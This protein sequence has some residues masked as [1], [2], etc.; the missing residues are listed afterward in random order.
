MPP[1]ETKEFL[2][3]LKIKS[4]II[5][6]VLGAALLQ[7]VATCAAILL[8]QQQASSDVTQELNVL[9]RKNI[10]QIARDV[11]RMAETANGLVQQQVASGLQVARDLMS[12][13]GTPA[14]STDKTVSWQAVN[15]LTKAVVPVTLPELTVGGVW[16]GQNRDPNA[17][18]PLVDDVKRLSGVTS[19]IFQRMNSEG[20][21]LR[22]ATNVEGADHKRA[23]GTYIP[24]VNPDG[25]PN[26]VVAAVLRGETFHGRAFV[27][28]AWYLTAYEPMRDSRGEIIGMLYVGVKQQGIASLRRSILD[29]KVGKTGYV[30]V[31]G[32]SG[33]QRGRYIISK[34][35]KRDGESIWNA[36]DADGNLVIQSIVKKALTL[37][38]GEVAYERY[39]WKN[40]GDPAPRRKI[41]AITY[42]KPW[43]WVIGAGSYEDEFYAAAQ[44]AQSGIFKMLW[45]SL[46]IGAA[47]LFAAALLAFF[48]GGTI[49]RPV[50]AMAQVARRLA[51]GKLDQTIEHRASDETGQLA[52]AFRDMQGQLQ[53]ISTE[54]ESLVTATTEGQLA[55]RA[56]AAS[57]DGVW[58]RMIE[59]LNSLADAYGAP[60]QMTADY[61]DR[62]AKGD[63]PRRIT[64]DFQG[65]FNAIKDNLNRCIG[66]VNL[67]V[68]DTQGLV[69]AAVEGRLNERADEARH[70][71]AYA[72]L[73]GGVNR[74]VDVLVGHLDALPAPAMVIDPD[75]T[76]R[77]MNG[78]GCGVIGR[79]QEQLVG[80]KCFDNFKTSDCHTDKCA[81]A[82]AMRNGAIATSETDAH[83]NGKS[84]DISYTGLP[85]RDAQGAVVG[86]FEVVTDLTQIKQGARETERGA[87]LARKQ[88]AF[89][90]K[91]IE[92]LVVNLDKVA[93]GDLAVS[94]AVAAADEDTQEVAHSFEQINA[95][96]KKTVTALQALIKDAN[97]L[98]EAGVAGQLDARADAARHQGEYRRIVEGVNATLDA[99]VTPINEA[100]TVLERLAD[101]DLQARVTGSYAGDFAKIKDA[102]NK[103]GEGLHAAIAQVNEAVGQVA[104]AA[105]QI[106]ATSQAVAQGASEQASSLEETSSALEQMTGQTKQNADNTQQARAVAKTT[107]ELAEKG[108]TSMQQM[109]AAMTNIRKSAEDTS[110]IIKD[111]NEI[112]FQ[113]NLLA[114]NA[115]VEAARAGDAG[116][117]FAVVAEEVRNL[118]LRA[119]EAANKTE[120]LIAQSAKLA[121]EG[122]TIS[123]DVSENL[124]QIVESIGKVA[125]FV[126]EIAVASEEQAKGI[127][128]VNRAVAEMDK[129]VQQAAANSEESSSAAEELSSQSQELAAMV[130]R[131]QLSHEKA[132]RA[133]PPAA[134]V[135]PM[136]PKPRAKGPSGG[137]GK[138][139]RQVAA[140]L[141]P[142]DD[143]DALADF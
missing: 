65:D 112:A 42:F 45:W 116:R 94:L 119:K 33:E 9:M 23:I 99:I 137:N 87:A 111:I 134:K 72:R 18:S 13:Q 27:V 105:E 26:P 120:G 135:T 131:F 121:N 104:S 75:F 68:D 78:A 41:A 58:Q 123:G 52:D 57:F 39:K 8:L 103:T 84:L 17:S 108:G 67:L 24:A 51:I 66:T 49:A 91:E 61:L 130:G 5:S 56:D 113:T 110:A 83:P 36:K 77:Y 19:T 98:A 102:L 141:I 96:V 80:T 21:M 101:Y 117:G 2:M 79:S 46:G 115:A 22:V 25:K 132:V 73:I 100:A 85:L 90:A 59:G 93:Q 35:G 143:E 12:R 142:L 109:V 124:T 107:Q 7:V 1:N 3:K 53:T 140:Q 128:Q 63:I 95:A 14:L 97:A 28:N 126:D 10:S 86:A 48:L 106:A 16:L 125:D 76:I 114:L 71:G 6:L 70:E 69:A 4:K 31:L 88:G 64:D 118:A 47:S 136:R 29:T 74:V 127:G 50:T 34:E 129:V 133:A 20:D 43:D 32:G 139:D 82:R 11:Y 15:Q 30:Y 81:C 38:K 55:V 44:R 37:K 92:K 89:Q 138:W 122:G 54:T 40:A 60:I 62:I